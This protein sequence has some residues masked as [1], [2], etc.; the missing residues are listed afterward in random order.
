MLNTRKLRR[1]CN[2]PERGRPEGVDVTES[3]AH[4]ANTQ[5]RAI[6]TRYAGCHFRSRLEAR[7]AVFFDFL[8]WQWRYEPQGYDL[9]SGRYLSDFFVTGSLYD[10]EFFEVKGVKPSP[11]EIQV[12]KELALETKKWVTF[13]GDIPRNP[14]RSIHGMGGFQVPVAPLCPCCRVDSGRHLNQVP[15]IGTGEATGRVWQA[16]T[17]ARSA[18]FEHGHS[19]A[20]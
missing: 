3:G 9:P 13:L 17:A 1:R 2:G 19:G 14:C 10:P 18:R 5:L 6:P 4:S 12:A 20:S 8:G 15:A 16:L 7:W 11:S